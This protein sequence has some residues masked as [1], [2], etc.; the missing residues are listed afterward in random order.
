[1]VGREFKGEEVVSSNVTNMDG[2]DNRIYFR[3]LLS[4]FKT[5]RGN[6]QE[7]RYVHDDVKNVSCWI[8]RDDNFS[9]ISC[10]PDKALEE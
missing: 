8:Y 6:F 7:V 1:M 3:G 4:E 5:R 9:G 10:L 2:N